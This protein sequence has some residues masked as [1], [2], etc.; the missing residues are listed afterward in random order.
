MRLKSDFE[1]VVPVSR[2]ILC[3]DFHRVGTSHEEWMHVI[4]YANPVTRGCILLAVMEEVDVVGIA[5]HVPVD[6]AVP[7]AFDQI[8]V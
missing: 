3:H 7:A 2:Q 8:A 4:R 1:R 6:F 5:V